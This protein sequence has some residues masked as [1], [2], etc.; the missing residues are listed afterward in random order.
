[1]LQL[2]LDLFTKLPFASQKICA[3]AMND[4]ILDSVRELCHRCFYGCKSLHRV[5]FGSSSS[6]EQIGSWC[7]GGSGLNEVNIPD[8]VRELCHR[9]F[10]NCKSLRRVTFGS[11]SSL[12]RACNACF[13]YTGVE[14]VGMPDGTCLRC[15][16]C[17]EERRL[18]EMEMTH[19]WA[20]AFGYGVH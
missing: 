1:M 5:T 10:C 15:Y 8:S 14:K 17:E 7:F 3:Y 12:K 19:E 20:I 2:L 6:L 11:S 4:G 18:R 9:C 13:Q 16:E